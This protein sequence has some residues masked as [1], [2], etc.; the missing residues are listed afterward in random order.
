M[1]VLP[2]HFELELTNIQYM[3]STKQSLHVYMSELVV[4]EAVLGRLASSSLADFR[5]YR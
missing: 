1:R 2:D 3:F 5:W 4:I